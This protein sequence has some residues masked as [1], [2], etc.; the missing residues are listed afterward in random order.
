[1]GTIER[2]MESSDVFISYAS[3]DKSKAEA[4]CRRLEA[5]GIRCWIAP[6]DIALGSD[7]GESIIE[8]INSTRVMVPVLSANANGSPFVRREV[9]RAASK[10]IALLPM[11]LED[12]PPS[13]SLEFFI[14][15]CQRLDAFPDPFEPHLD[16]LAK[17]LRTMLASRKQAEA[18]PTRERASDTRDERQPQSPAQNG[19][20]AQ[21][22]PTTIEPSIEKRTTPVAAKPDAPAQPTP[23]APQEG[24]AV[25]LL[26][27]ELLRDVDPAR[28]RK[29]F[30][31]AARPVRALLCLP[32][33]KGGPLAA[34][35]AGLGVE[36]EILLGP[37]V[38]APPHAH[39]FTLRAPAGTTPEQQIEFALALSDIVM[40]VPGLEQN[41]WVRTAA[42]LD[43]PRIVPG[44]PLPPIELFADDLHSLDPDR[45]GMRRRCGRALCGRLEQFLIELVTFHWLGRGGGTSLR[46]LRRS[47]RREWLP[48]AYFAP[49]YW[50]ALA[51]D[52][53][54][55]ESSKVLTLFNLLDRSAL[56]GSYLH[57]DLVWL[58]HIG[59]AFA[60]LAAVAG[61]LSEAHH[62]AW[63]IVEL[64]TLVSVMLMVIVAR[65]TELQDRWTA[66]RLGAEQ[67]RIA[68]MSMPLLVLPS[69][70]ATADKAPPA[71]KHA[72]K[73]TRFGAHALG[74]VKRVIRD[75]GLP[76]LAP[77]LTPVEAADWLRLIVQDQIVYHRSN[78]RRLEHA[79]SG[80][81]R[82]TQLI[83]LV[84]IIGVTAHLYWPDATHLLL[85]TAAAPAF[86]AALHGTGTRLG[87]VHR[88]ALS[89]DLERELIEVDT[90]LGDVQG[91]PPGSWQEVRRLAFAAAEVM[92]KENSSWHG[93]V[94]R[95]RDDLP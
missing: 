87:I 71:D 86:A 25:V 45:P 69:A 95:Y 82:L 64:V 7:Y 80:L 78:H 14:S 75:H 43:K 85:A 39:G 9:E 40:V 18:A 88:A 48:G 60:V 22:H 3:E 15:N 20:P 55:R 90:A 84:A 63:G 73:D 67:L 21:S 65:G 83:F 54:V 93:L 76:R 66:C 53:T 1:M 12:V 37:L 68:L 10:E 58:E 2:A 44:E 57:R 72:S 33:D 89:G 42:K 30:A 11:R 52:R 38:P 50:Q 47:F 74:Q 26:L 41:P 94:R 59:A 77:T 49:Q 27:P 35:V 31:D 92:G 36:T 81:R 29:T 32:D 61:H 51:P 6:R 17:E 16:R 34:L 23:H 70:L 8:A 4:A 91:R 62:L 24:T 19:Q 79:E 5:D 56:Y 28:L 13:K 46:R